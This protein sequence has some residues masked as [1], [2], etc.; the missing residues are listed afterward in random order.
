MKLVWEEANLFCVCVCGGLGS[1]KCPYWR[2]IGC[3]EAP[4]Q[5]SFCLVPPYLLAQILVVSE[6]SHMASVGWRSCCWICG[7]SP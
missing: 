3:P 1:R 7:R 6:V 2:L 5:G 4:E